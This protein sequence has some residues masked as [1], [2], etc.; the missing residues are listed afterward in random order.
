MQS[1]NSWTTMLQWVNVQETEV[2]LDEDIDIDLVCEMFNNEELSH[3]DDDPDEEEYEGYMGNYSPTVEYWYHPAV[4]VIL[5]RTKNSKK[6]QL[7][8]SERHGAN[9][10][11]SRH[12]M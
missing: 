9:C 7:Q 3:P 6:L 4:L 12:Q 1:F 11:C 10:N 2:M 8:S 5:P